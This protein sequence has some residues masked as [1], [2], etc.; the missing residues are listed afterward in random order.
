MNKKELRKIYRTARTDMEETAVENL[1][2]C[3]ENRVLSSDLFNGSSS[4]YIYVDFHNEVRTGRIIARA[5]ELG[6][7]VAVPRISGDSM[8]FF[9]ISSK[10]DLEP[11]YLGIMEPKKDCVQAYDDRALMIMPGIA[12]DMKL[13]RIGSGG[14]YYDRYLA[15][16]KKMHPFKLAICY[17]YQITRVNIEPYG[18][19][20]SVD[21][22]LTEKRVFR[23]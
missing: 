18:L 1:S 9:Y 20:E 21:M 14:G 17:D 23:A 8:E 19:D 12:F 6:K 13:N 11:G 22:I 2:N 4:V 16:H 10:D 15:A 3:I 7:K 5:L